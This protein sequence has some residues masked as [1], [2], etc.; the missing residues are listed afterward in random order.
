M[1]DDYQHTGTAPLDV[2]ALGVDFMVTGALK[3]LLGPAGIAFL[4][5]RRDARS[6]GSSRCRPAGSA[7]SIRLPSA[8]I[9]LDW[10][11]SARRFETG[12]AAGAERVRGGRR[13]ALAPRVGAAAIEA[14][15]SRLVERFVTGARERGFDVATPDDAANG[16]GRW[17][18]V[19]IDRRGRAG[20]PARGRAASSR[21][22]AAPACAC[23]STPT[24]TTRTSMGCSRRSTRNAALLARDTARL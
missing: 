17:W 15:M 16:A 4:Y 22:P 18:C 20:R 8:S 24:T 11:A 10:A 21:P 23:R 9:A 5:V 14:Q 2:H 7:A 3:Y 13:P 1:L 12:S 6:S 19:R